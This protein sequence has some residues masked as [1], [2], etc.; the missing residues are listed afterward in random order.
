MITAVRSVTAAS[1]LRA[2]ISNV[3]GS[4]STK[5]GSAYWRKTTLRVATKV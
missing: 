4:E 3:S 5:T 1:S 2:S